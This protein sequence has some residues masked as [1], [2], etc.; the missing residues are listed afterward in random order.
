MQKMARDQSGQLNEN[1][2]SVEDLLETF[3]KLGFTKENLQKK[4]QETLDK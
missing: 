2:P 4:I 1:E 3:G